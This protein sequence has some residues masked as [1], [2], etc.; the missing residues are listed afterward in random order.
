M[1]W[2]QYMEKADWGKCRRGA[3]TALNC[4]L[5]FLMVSV[6]TAG[7]GYTV[8]LGD[9]FTH[10]VRVGVFHASL[11]RYFAAS[12]QYMKEIYL[13]WQ[14]TYFAMFIQAFLS[15]INNFGMGQLR[16]VMMGNALFFFGALLLLV[17]NVLGFALQERKMLHLR[18][19]VFTLV[20]F[21]VLNGQIFTE[22]FF[23][24][25]GATAYGIPFSVMLLSVSFF[26][27]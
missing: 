24:F 14:G 18:L 20:L 21:G 19:T 22:I 3:A 26:L 15:P 7:A 11:P 4:L 13:D 5:I 27:M 17:W 25:S 23:W 1:K 9:D 6:I 10:G 8:L 16:A 2:K 12:L